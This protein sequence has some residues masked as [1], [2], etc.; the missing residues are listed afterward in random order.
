VTDVV[1]VPSGRKCRRSS[2][3]LWLTDEE[4]FT[5]AVPAVYVRTRAFPTE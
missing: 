2:A 1:V 5:S 3:T 4:M